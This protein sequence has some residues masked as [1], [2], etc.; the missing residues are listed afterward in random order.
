LPA[1]SVAVVLKVVVESFATEA[2]KPGEENV[3]A[4]PLAAGAPEQSL[5]V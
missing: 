2:V 3:A 5:V 4:E 1:A